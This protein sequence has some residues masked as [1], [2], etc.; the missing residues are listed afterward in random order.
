VLYV[1]ASHQ[2]NP[3]THAF[4]RDQALGERVRFLVDA[5]SAAIDALGLRRPE[6]EP[7]EAGV[8]EPATYVIDRAGVVRFADVRSDFQIWIDPATVIAALQEAGE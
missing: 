1:L 6:P 4:I 2:V 7:I 8:P 5:D 3:K